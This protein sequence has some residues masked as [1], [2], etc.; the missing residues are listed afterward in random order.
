MLRRIQILLTSG[1]AGGSNS[2]H[3]QGCEHLFYRNYMCSDSAV[4]FFEIYIIFLMYL[5]DDMRYN[6]CHTKNLYSMMYF[7]LRFLSMHNTFM[8]VKLSNNIF[9]LFINNLF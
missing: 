8:F 5:T 9:L 1:N 3:H 7:L 2:W 6:L 4:Q